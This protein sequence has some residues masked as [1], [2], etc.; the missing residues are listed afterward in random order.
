MYTVSVTGPSTFCS[1]RPSSTR[2]VIVT[3]LLGPLHWFSSTAPSRTDT[4]PVVESTVNQ[5]SGVPVGVMDT[6][7]YVMTPAFT[8]ST[9][10]ASVALM[11]A[12][13]VPGVAASG[14]YAVRV[15]ECCST[16][17]ELGS[18]AQLPDATV[19][20]SYMPLDDL[21]APASD[22]VMPPVGFPPIVTVSVVD[23]QE[24]QPGRSR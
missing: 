17:G 22:S 24:Q 15:A 6:S 14:M 10:S 2:M 20:S 18:M 16:G 1:G 11:M 23:V 9:E 5:A 3:T 13:T 4:T 21:Y 7:V 8:G 12:T 19:L